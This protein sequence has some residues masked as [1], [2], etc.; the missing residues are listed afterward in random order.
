MIGR[1][2]EAGFV[3]PTPISSLHH[4]EVLLQYPFIQLSEE[5]HKDPSKV[6]T[7]GWVGGGRFNVDCML[8][9][10]EHCLENHHIYGNSSRMTV[11][12]RYQ[13]SKKKTLEC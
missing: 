6:A 5:E 13:Y 12:G 8:K 7:L 2:F 9:M 4:G 1:L 10:V 11:K 3:T